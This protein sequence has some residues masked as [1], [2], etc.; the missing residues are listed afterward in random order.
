MTSLPI[1]YSVHNLYKGCHLSKDYDDEVRFKKYLKYQVKK[2]H[3]HICSASA[4]LLYNTDGIPVMVHYCI[5]LG[6]ISFPRIW[7]C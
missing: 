3:T 4:S 6:N 2:G 1:T 5:F 7:R